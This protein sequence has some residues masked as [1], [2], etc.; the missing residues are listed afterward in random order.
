MKKFTL[1]AALIA[2]VGL[3]SLASA[4]EFGS[5]S[6]KSWGKTADGKEV[7]LYTLTNAKGMTMTVTNRGATIVSL[8]A[9]DRDGKYEKVAVGYD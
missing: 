9:P 1:I 7:V 5:V 8:T 2:V 3:S 4:A 6:A